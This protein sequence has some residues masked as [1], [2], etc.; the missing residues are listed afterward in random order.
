[1]RHASIK[2]NFSAYLDNELPPEEMQA[3]AAHMHTCNACKQQL[4]EIQLG[5]VAA[6]AFEEPNWDGAERLWKN[7]Q[8]EKAA[9]NASTRLPSLVPALTQRMPSFLGL[10]PAA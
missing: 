1:M 5:K 4:R 8:K 10:R 9:F 7:I 3:I 6:T 2:R